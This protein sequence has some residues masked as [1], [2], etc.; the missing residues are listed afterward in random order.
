MAFYVGMGV[1]V[2]ASAA[3]IHTFGDV[4]KM[5]YWREASGMCWWRLR[6]LESLPL[7]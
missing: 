1:G 7:L 3:S 4:R 2:I 6:W 5:V